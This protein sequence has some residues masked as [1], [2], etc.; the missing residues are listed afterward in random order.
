MDYLCRGGDDGI[1]IKW[2]VTDGPE[3][4]KVVKWCTRYA[5][6]T[7]WVPGPVSDWEARVV[8]KWLESSVFV[9]LFLPVT[10]GLT[11]YTGT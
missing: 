9:Q 5:V 4:V 3:K 11:M 6:T 7:E 10:L 8:V 2:D 1:T